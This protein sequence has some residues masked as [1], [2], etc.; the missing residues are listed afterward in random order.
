MRVERDV[1]LR[2]DNRDQPGVVAR[3]RLKSHRP[4]RRGALRD[5]VEFAGQ[6]TLIEAPITGAQERAAAPIEL[7]GEPQAR[8]DEVFGI[9]GSD[10]ADHALG[11]TPFGVHHGKIGIDR[12]G[13]I[14]SEPAST[15]SRLFTVIVSLT[16]AAGVTNTPP[17]IDGAR[18]TA[19]DG[20][21]SLSMNRTPP[22]RILSNDE[23]RARSA[24]PP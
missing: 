2:I 7:R 23:R 14:E 17:A 24:S 13:V 18:N 3:R 8:R 12:A 21:P 16:N 4:R 20:A 22:G 19:C 1:D 6:D 11:L 10:A 15:V 5:R 9:H